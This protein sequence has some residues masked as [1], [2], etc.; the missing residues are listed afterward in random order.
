MKHYLYLIALFFSSRPAR[1]ASGARAGHLHRRQ[2]REFQPL[3]GVALNR[4]C[5]IMN[6]NN[7]NPNGSSAPLVISLPTG[8]W[9]DALSLTVLS[10]SGTA[11]QWRTLKLVGTS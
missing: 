10:S 11:V 2:R 8:V 5:E 9:T 7:G 1:P 4:S 3:R 6:S